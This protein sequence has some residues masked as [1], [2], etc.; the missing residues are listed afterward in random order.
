[1]PGEL[2]SQTS[3]FV[4]SME[5]DCRQ[6]SMYTSFVLYV[7]SLILLC[8]LCH[9]MRWIVIMSLCMC[10]GIF[11]FIQLCM[12]NAMVTFIIWLLLFVS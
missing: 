9:C 3:R 11:T 5:R 8:G 1:M 6:Y 10:N 2:V 7:R 12:F 4:I